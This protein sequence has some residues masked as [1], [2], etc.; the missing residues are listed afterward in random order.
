MRLVAA[1]GDELLAWLGSVDLQQLGSLSKDIFSDAHQLD[2]SHSW[3][4]FWPKF[5][6]N[7]LCNSEK[8]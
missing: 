4:V 1:S 7:R 5:R 3:E 8:A 2:S 6:A